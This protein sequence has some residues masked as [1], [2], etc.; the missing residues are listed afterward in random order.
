MA[1]GAHKLPFALGT[2]LRLRRRHTARPLLV[3]ETQI[4]VQQ[5]AGSLG[6]VW[7]EFQMGGTKVVQI[8]HLTINVKMKYL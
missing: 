2:V 6:F 1:H 3:P 7:K 4:A 8:R 5:E